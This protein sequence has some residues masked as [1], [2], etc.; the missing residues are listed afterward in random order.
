MFAYKSVKDQM[1]LVEK[2]KDKIAQKSRQN[3]ADIDFVAIMC[4]V[5]I[6]EE[7]EEKEEETTNE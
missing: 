1:R 5:E 6:P 7:V 4:D 3:K 2:E